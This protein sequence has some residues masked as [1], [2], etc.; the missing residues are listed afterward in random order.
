LEE[1]K[2]DIISKN[3]DIINFVVSLIIKAIVIPFLSN[4]S[5]NPSVAQKAPFP[6]AANP[7]RFGVLISPPKQPMSEYPKSSAMIRTIF[8][9]LA[10]EREPFRA[11]AFRHPGRAADAAPKPKIFR[12]SRLV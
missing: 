10:E 4:H 11:I 1:Y 8:G 12:K 5:T 7:S 3:L 9:F 6:P 2:T